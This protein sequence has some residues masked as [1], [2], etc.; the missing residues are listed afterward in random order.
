MKDI[1]LGLDRDIRDIEQE[2]KDYQRRIDKLK[3]DR[4]LL[5]I[6]EALT[7]IAS[8]DWEKLL[9]SPVGAPFLRRHFPSKCL[10]FVWDSVYSN[11]TVIVK[12]IHRRFLVDV[13]ERARDFLRMLNSSIRVIVYAGQ[14]TQQY[15][16]FERT[17][18]MWFYGISAFRS[19]D[20]VVD[21]IVE[22]AASAEYINMKDVTDDEE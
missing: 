17:Q 19:I 9:V 1:I 13:S 11:H 3:T 5:L 10:D 15:A 14:E 4:N 6:D 21:K 2:L 12:P 8:R 22:I 20:L 16:R 18:E 7:N